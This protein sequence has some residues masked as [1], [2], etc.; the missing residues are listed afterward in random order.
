MKP[1]KKLALPAVASLCVTLFLTGC[2]S[3]STEASSTQT[4]SA[5]ETREAGVRGS[6]LCIYNNSQISLSVTWRGYPQARIVAPNATDCNS[7]YESGET[8]D[9]AAVLDFEDPA[10][11]GTTQRWFFA[12][13]NP[14]IEQPH[15]ELYY[16][17]GDKKS[18]ICL[19]YGEDVQRGLQQSGIRGD[20][21]R[22]QDSSDNIEFTLTVTDAQGNNF[23][24][25][26]SNCG[27]FTAWV[28]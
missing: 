26:A 21:K 22:I 13:N 12:A 19:S 4:T 23:A 5:E 24:D 15:A 14:W 2:T 20:L 17:S 27:K 11:P 28:T 1:L 18:G 3:V 6:R 8:P 9:I 10:K 16:E 25:D 7:G